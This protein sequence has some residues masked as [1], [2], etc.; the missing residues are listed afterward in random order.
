[1][2]EYWPDIPDHSGNALREE[3]TLEEMFVL[4]EKRISSLRE[5]LVAKNRDIGGEET[6]YKLLRIVAVLNA[7]A[8]CGKS[9]YSD[10]AKRVIEFQATMKFAFEFGLREA[11]K[12]SP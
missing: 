6:G 10:C 4:V 12:V 8:A 7:I 1:V 3:L 5:H 9:E 2:N 11:A